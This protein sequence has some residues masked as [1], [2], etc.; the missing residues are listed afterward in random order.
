MMYEL[1]CSRATNELSPHVED[2]IKP[3]VET[4]ARNKCVYNSVY[5]DSLMFVSI[6]IKI[7][8]ID[9]HLVDR[10]FLKVMCMQIQ[11]NTSNFQAQ[12]WMEY[13]FPISTAEHIFT[14]RDHIVRMQMIVYYLLDS[15][16]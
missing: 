7:F 12:W 6:V 2:D 14:E 4:C 3:V 10:M 1:S 9:Q 11:A 13:Q 5:H 8:E 15:S 16:T